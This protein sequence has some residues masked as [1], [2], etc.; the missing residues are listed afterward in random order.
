MHHPR[1]DEIVGAK[2]LKSAR[3]LSRVEITAFGHQ[4]FEEANFRVVDEEHELASFGKIRLR[5]EQG[6][7]LKPFVAVARQRRRGCGKESTAKAITGGVYAS[8]GHNGLDCVQG[9][10][11]AQAIII[12]KIKIAI[13]ATGFFQEIMKTVWPL[14]TR[15]LTSEFRGD[16]SRM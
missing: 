1:P 10:R 3:H 11:H 6:Y 8:T 12:L 2:Q 7:G 4:V 5:R 14:S 15:Y 9:G 16:R 13:F